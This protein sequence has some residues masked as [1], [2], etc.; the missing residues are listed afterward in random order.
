MSVGGGERPGSKLFFFLLFFFMAGAVT[1]DMESITPS[2]AYHWQAPHSELFTNYH[3]FRHCLG[4]GRD[5]LALWLAG[6]HTQHTLAH[7]LPQMCIQNT[8]HP[9]WMAGVAPGSTSSTAQEAGNW[10]LK[11]LNAVWPWSDLRFWADNGSETTARRSGV[12]T[13]ACKKAIADESVLK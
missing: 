1:E 4:K 6:R 8:G 9:C 3:W 2:S 13:S 10:K 5:T 11:T 12:F 7:K